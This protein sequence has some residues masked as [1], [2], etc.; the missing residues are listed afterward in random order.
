ML[1]LQFFKRSFCRYD[2]GQQDLV[3]SQRIGQLGSISTSRVS[4]S[5]ATGMNVSQI[6][7]DVA[8]LCRCGKFWGIISAR[9]R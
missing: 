5:L 1:H 7:A 6:C 3:L 2:A 4:K 8:N 9:P